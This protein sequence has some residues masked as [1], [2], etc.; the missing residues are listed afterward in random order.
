[1]MII[2]LEGQ[3]MTDF[4][5]FEAIEIESKHPDVEYEDGHSTP[6][7]K[8]SGK[9]RII[10]NAEAHMNNN[11]DK[12]SKDNQASSNPDSHRKVLSFWTFFFMNGIS[13][14]FSCLFAFH[15]FIKIY[16]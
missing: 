9:N 7:R 4:I 15:L 8:V 13:N 14:N 2:E 16:I 10:F 6:S 3:T 11:E 12:D 5:L 1:M